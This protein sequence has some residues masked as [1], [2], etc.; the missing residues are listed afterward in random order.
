M[1]WNFMP[2]EQG[3]K[4][5]KTCLSSSNSPR[6]FKKH[7][8]NF[9][10]ANWEQVLRTALASITAGHPSHQQPRVNGRTA[11]VPAPAGQ[12]TA[13]EAPRAAVP[14]SAQLLAQRGARGGWPWG[15]R[16]A[17]RGHLT[18][19]RGPARQLC[20]QGGSRTPPG[21]SGRGTPEA[22]GPAVTFRC[23]LRLRLW[24]PR[25]PLSEQAVK[26]PGPVPHGP[27]PA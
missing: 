13:S 1:W 25:E 11:H 7:G 9:W 24:D 16:R 19:E 2:E 23:Q 26:P 3:K 18:R 4:K 5:K 17:R 8:N 20:P 21:P 12:H 22:L 15:E 6:A 14:H 27:S 10:S